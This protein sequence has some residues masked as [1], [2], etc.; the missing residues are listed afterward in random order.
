MKTFGILVLNLLG[1]VI[2]FNWI[3][4]RWQVVAML[5]MFGVCIAV[6]DMNWPDHMG[7]DQGA[8]LRALGNLILPQ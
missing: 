5:V 1:E 8:L 3:S 4:D 2:M 7:G 6:A